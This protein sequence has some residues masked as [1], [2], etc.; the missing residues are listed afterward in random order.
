MKVTP[1]DLEKSP[2]FTDVTSD[3][4]LEILSPKNIEEMSA[5]DGDRALSPMAK[6]ASLYQ[7]YGDVLI[8]L[9]EAFVA[10]PRELTFELQS[11]SFPGCVMFIAA[12]MHACATYALMTSKT[13][14]DIS[15]IDDVAYGLLA[16]GRL[17][18][19]IR[20]TNARDEASVQHTLTESF[21]E[22]PDIDITDL[23]NTID[24]TWQQIEI[25]SGILDLPIIPGTSRA[26]DEWRRISVLSIDALKRRAVVLEESLARA[27]SSRGK[28]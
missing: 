1:A 11:K 18:D 8:P 12:A 28:T 17:E 27:K 13:R 25:R 26:F 20:A 19:M 16:D 2:F 22:N 3:A 5:L 14:T 10:E 23:K 6:Q 24:T 4:F 15:V 21:T 9:I 7:S